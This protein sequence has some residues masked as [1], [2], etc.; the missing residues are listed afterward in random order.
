MNG[1]HKVFLRLHW[2]ATCCVFLAVIVV[3]LTFAVPGAFPRVGA[4]LPN[5]G[6]I[7]PIGVGLYSCFL[8]VLVIAT[9]W[10][11]IEYIRL[12]VNEARIAKGIRTDAVLTS[13]AHREA[14]REEY[15]RVESK[16]GLSEGYLGAL[17][18]FHFAFAITTILTVKITALR[19]TVVPA[20]S[21]VFSQLGE[22]LTTLTGASLL[23]LVRLI[24]SLV[25]GCGLAVLLGVPLGQNDRL[26]KT[27]DPHIK[28]ASSL[29]PIVLA[30]VFVAKSRW[31]SRSVFAPMT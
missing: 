24:V 9:V 4:K 12:R 17:A 29:P 26:R 11:V 5:G 31:V 23:S 8:L 13:E 22:N 14:Q 6:L 27:L 16:I 18:I 20:P 15:R 2:A 3:V 30:G 21:D 25:L 1:D 10:F 28:W 19:L 7:K